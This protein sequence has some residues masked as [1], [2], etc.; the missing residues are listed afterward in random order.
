MEPTGL[1]NQVPTEKLVVQP[2]QNAT[3]SSESPELQPPCHTALAGSCQCMKSS[4]IGGTIL[5][6]YVHHRVSV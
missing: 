3:V 4:S 6:A 5:E 1:C 2:Q